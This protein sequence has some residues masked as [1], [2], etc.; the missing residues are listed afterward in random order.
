MSSI[1]STPRK[2]R[3]GGAL[4]VLAASGALSWYALGASGASKDPAVTTHRTAP[5][6]TEVRPKPRPRPA[7]EQPGWSAVTKYRG[8]FVVDRRSFTETD[9]NVVMVY[10]FRVRQVRFALHAGSE[11]PPGAAYAAGPGAGPQISAAEARVIVAA[12]NGGFKVA[13]GS[14]GFELRRHVFVPLQVGVASLVIDASGAAQV[15]VW[16]EDLPFRGEHVESVRQ[17]LQPLVMD[18]KPSPVIDDIYAWG[19]SWHGASA[20]ARSAVGEDKRG[21]I[22]Y[23]AS[24]NALPADL[25]TA[26]ID[27]GAVRAMELDINP[28]WVQLD[29]APRPGGVLVAGIPGQNPPGDQYMLGWTR[30][31]VTVMER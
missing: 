6:T 11:D 12:F 16:G 20:V 19:S 25:A 21:D 2:V 17:N 28:A 23:A 27:A 8:A 26:L 31:F 1:T 3:V 5:S 29:S 13:S 30:D 4:V 22:L 14:G 7:R 18:G 10:R 15:G 9:G 24:M